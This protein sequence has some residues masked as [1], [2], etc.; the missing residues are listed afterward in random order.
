MTQEALTEEPKNKR[1]ASKK[2]TRQ[3][4]L[5]AARDLFVKKGYEAT[6]IRDIAKAMGMSTGAMFANFDSKHQLFVVIMDE[7]LVEYGAHLKVLNLESLPP[8]EQAL[9]ALMVDH[10]FFKPRYRLLEEIRYLEGRGDQNAMHFQSCRRMFVEPYLVT[11]FTKPT[12][13]VLWSAYDALHRSTSRDGFVR[14][15]VREEIQDIL[16]CFAK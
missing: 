14:E 1:H 3:K 7:E 16:R 6:T 2:Q 11:A 8:A 12:A 9:S 5:T 10:D 15:L 13:R 4:A